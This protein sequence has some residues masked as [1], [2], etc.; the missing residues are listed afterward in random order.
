MR[1]LAWFFVASALPP[2]QQIDWQQQCVQR[3]HRSQSSAGCVAD[4]G[5][6]RADCQG[7]HPHRVAAAESCHHQ[8]CRDPPDHVSQIHAALRRTFVLG[9]TPLAARRIRPDWATSLAPTNRATVSRAS[10]LT[11]V[12]TWLLKPVPQWADEHHAMKSMTV[13]RISRNI[14]ASSRPAD[15]A[16]VAMLVASSSRRQRFAMTALPRVSRRARA[17]AADFDRVV[18]RNPVAPSH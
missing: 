10:P 15:R 5:D 4:E 18:P 17:T 6:V 7:T 13:S 8:P 11:W 3:Q 1:R 16:S 14:C 9:R 12:A 2:S